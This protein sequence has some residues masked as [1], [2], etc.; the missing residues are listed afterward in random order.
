MPPMLR[1]PKMGWT[2]CSLVD[3]Q[4][5]EPPWQPV[6]VSIDGNGGARETIKFLTRQQVSYSMEFTLPNRALRIT[7]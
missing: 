3:M 4:R 5:G 2:G 7:S 6:P 1:A